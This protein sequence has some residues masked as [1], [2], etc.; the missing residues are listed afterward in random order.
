[1][2]EAKNVFVVGPKTVYVVTH[3]RS[4][5]DSGSV[6][7]VGQFDSHDRALKIAQALSD[8]TPGA[9]VDDEVADF[10][11]VE[12]ATGPVKVRPGGSA[13]LASDHLP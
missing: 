13:A 2:S 3:M 1:M 12:T 10:D 6:E 11:V 9:T 4:D 7:T 5:L 8:A